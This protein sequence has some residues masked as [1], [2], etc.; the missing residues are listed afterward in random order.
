MFQIFE[1]SKVYVLAQQ[2]SRRFARTRVLE[3]RDGCLVLVTTALGLDREIRADDLLRVDL[4][5]PPASRQPAASLCS[6]CRPRGPTVRTV[7]S[8]LYRS[9]FL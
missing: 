2:A 9:T 3:V 4:P 8:R 6:Q 1:L 5:P 7:R